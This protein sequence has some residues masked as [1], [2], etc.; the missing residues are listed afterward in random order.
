MYSNYN[1][2]LTA[3][4]CVNK[5]IDDNCNAKCFLNKT[6]EQEQENQSTEQ[7]KN[8][9]F[10]C[11]ETLSHTLLDNISFLDLQIFVYSTQYSFLYSSQPPRPPIS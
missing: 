10:F 8:D 2:T 11:Q 7:K 3:S 6:Q 4:C 5:G 9:G 1:E